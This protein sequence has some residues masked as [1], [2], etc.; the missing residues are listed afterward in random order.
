MTQFLLS[1]RW[2]CGSAGSRLTLSST[3]STSRSAVFSLFLSL[4]YSFGS[5]LYLAKDPSGNRVALPMFS[6]PKRGGPQSPY[7]IFVTVYLYMKV[8]TVSEKAGRTGEEKK[9]TKSRWLFKIPNDTVAIRQKCMG[10]RHTDAKTTKLTT[11]KGGGKS[12]VFVES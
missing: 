3:R 5:C 1:S 6:R 10:R 8:F 11:I 2:A 9:K 7:S 12:K 4:C